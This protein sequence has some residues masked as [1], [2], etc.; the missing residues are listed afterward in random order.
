MVDGQSK[1]HQIDHSRRNY[2]TDQMRFRS[3]YNLTIANM[4]QSFVREDFDISV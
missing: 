1:T 3:R 2:G 4:E